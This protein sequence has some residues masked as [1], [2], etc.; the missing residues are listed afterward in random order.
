VYDNQSGITQRAGHSRCGYSSSF[1]AWSIGRIV[2]SARKRPLK[3]G[4]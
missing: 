2:R 3:Q 4:Y 1:H